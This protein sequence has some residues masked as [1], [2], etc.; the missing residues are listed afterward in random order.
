M[1]ALTMSAATGTTAFQIPAF[2]RQVVG[3]APSQTAI[4]MSQPGAAT[5][6]GKG[7]SYNPDK[8]ADEKNKGNYRKLSEALE[9]SVRI[10]RTNIVSQTFMCA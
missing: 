5:G 6:A 10:V 3:V 2:N 4:S 9:V 1:I 7:L 8:Y